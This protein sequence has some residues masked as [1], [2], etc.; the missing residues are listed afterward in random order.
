[1]QHLS[2]FKYLTDPKVEDVLEEDWGVVFLGRAVG[3]PFIKALPPT[4]LSGD[5]SDVFRVTKPDES[6]A[7]DRAKTISARFK[8]SNGIFPTHCPPPVINL[9]EAKEGGFFQ[10]SLWTFGKLVGHVS[11]VKGTSTVHALCDYTTLGMNYKELSM[12]MKTTSF[13]T[14][15]TSFA[16][17]FRGVLHSLPLRYRLNFVLDRP[18]IIN[19]TWSMYASDYRDSLEKFNDKV[20]QFFRIRE[21]RDDKEPVSFLDFMMISIYRSLVA[22]V[23]RNDKHYPHFR[24]FVALAKERKDQFRTN[25]NVQLIYLYAMKRAHILGGVMEGFTKKFRPE[26]DQLLFDGGRKNPAYA[27]VKEVCEVFLFLV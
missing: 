22:D 18:D 17:V 3:T 4:D 25:P 16:K 1:M 13:V 27:K 5:F 21:A 7:E 11:P 9:Q 15:V 12:D 23:Y 20:A 24:T 6:D 2:S 14:M 19:A 26:V 10:G 8:K